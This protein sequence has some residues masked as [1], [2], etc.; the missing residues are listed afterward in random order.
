MSHHLVSPL[1]EPSDVVPKLN[2]LEHLAMLRSGEDTVGFLSESTVGRRGKMDLIQ[3]SSLDLVLELR[4]GKR[5][6]GW[7]AS[8]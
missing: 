8:E 3:W 5:M 1:L 2:A 7:W 4:L 6:E